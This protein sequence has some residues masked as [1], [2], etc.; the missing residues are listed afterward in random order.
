MEISPRILE[1]LTRKVETTSRKKE[2]HVCKKEALVRT[3]E[4]SSYQK[5]ISHKKTV[6]LKIQKNLPDFA[7]TF[8]NN[9]LFEIDWENCKLLKQLNNG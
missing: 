6:E 5:D 7:K 8:N 2:T 1:T 4:T 3:R 9:L